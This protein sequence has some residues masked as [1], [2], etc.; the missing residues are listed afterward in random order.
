[1][2]HRGWVYDIISTVS[3][4]GIV[5]A[6]ASGTLFGGFCLLAGATGAT[7]TIQDSAANVIMKTVGGANAMFIVNLQYRLSYAFS[8]SKTNKDNKI[9]SHIATYVKL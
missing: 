7:L 2:A 6:T 8:K 1:M 9:E 5:V 3:G 4:G